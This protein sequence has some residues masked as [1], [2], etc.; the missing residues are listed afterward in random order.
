MLGQRRGRAERLAAVRAA[1]TLATVGM[2][3]LVSAEVGEL[4]VGLVADVAAERLDAAVYV[5]VLLEAARRGERLAAAGTLMLADTE[6]TW[7]IE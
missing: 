4:G 7:V 2:H 5:L 6:N 3:A 1:D